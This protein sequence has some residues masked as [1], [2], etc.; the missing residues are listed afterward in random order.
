MTTRAR[1]RP[2]GAQLVL[3]ALLAIAVLTTIK[4]TRER[5]AEAAKDVANTMTQGAIAATAAAFAARFLLLRLGLVFLAPWMA[6]AAAIAAFA[7]VGA[8]QLSSRE[9]GLPELPGTGG[10]HDPSAG[11]LPPCDGVRWYDNQ[12]GVWR[13]SQAT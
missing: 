1:R 13:C 6:G 11:E 4:A 5:G 2:G 10:P 7:A 8:Y 9:L 12:A 3:F